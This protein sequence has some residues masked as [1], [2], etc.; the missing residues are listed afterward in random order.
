LLLI[1]PKV[2]SLS[3]TA[4]RAYTVAVVLSLGKIILSP[5]SRYAKEGLVYIILASPLSRQPSSYLECTKVNI[6]LSYNIRSISNAKYT[7]PIT[8]NS[9]QVP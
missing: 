8:L 2:T 6:Y 4:R 5:C 1:I 7:Y 9:L 3:S